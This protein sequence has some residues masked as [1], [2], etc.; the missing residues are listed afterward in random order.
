[1]MG[2][3]MYKKC[4][5]CGDEWIVKV[6]SSLGVCEDCRWWG[7]YL[8]YDETLMVLWSL[9]HGKLIFQETEGCWA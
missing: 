7:E 2:K 8:G 5:V 4:E 6:I 9:Y 3:V 1:M